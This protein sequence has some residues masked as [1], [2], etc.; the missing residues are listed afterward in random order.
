M[1]ATGGVFRVRCWPIWGTVG[2]GSG[3][4]RG[5]TVCDRK[6]FASGRR[7]RILISVGAGCYR[8]T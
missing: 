6:G 4:G 1:A 5:V 2:R 7:V 3:V 8:G